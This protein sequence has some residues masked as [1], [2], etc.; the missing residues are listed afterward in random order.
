MPV[1]VEPFATVMVFVLGL[2]IGSFLNVCILRLPL[3]ESIVSPRSHCPKCNTTLRW[4]HNIPVLSWMLL[5][6]KCASCGVRISARYAVIE[7]MTAVI[8]VLLW[9]AYGP[10]ITFGISAIL[11]LALLVLFFTDLDHKLLP[12]LVTLP[13]F[14]V[15]VAVAWVNP[16]LGPGSSWSRLW[17]S[18]AGA[19][20]GAGVLWGIGAL[21]SRLRGIEAMGMGDVKMMAMVGAF[22]GPTGVLVTLF[23]ASITGAVIGVALIPLRGG[24]MRDTLPFGCF[25]APAAAI[26]LLWGDDLVG[27]YLRLLTPGS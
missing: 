27:A 22:T 15:G 10:T 13:G 24:S 25:L 3:G 6:G 4:Y 23:G 17:A 2:L 21:Y 19:A 14:L 18:L 5:R 1:L 20:L 8:L 16:F 7:L 11:L 9:R 26:A 12:D